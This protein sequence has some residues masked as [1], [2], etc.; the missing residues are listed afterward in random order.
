[1]HY[2]IH[3]QPGNVFVFVFVMYLVFVYLKDTHNC[4]LSNNLSEFVKH[5]IG[6]EPTGG[7]IDNEKVKVQP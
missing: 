3:F 7:L 2:L 4:A 6:A 1:M 5:E